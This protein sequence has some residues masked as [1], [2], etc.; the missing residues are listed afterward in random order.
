M[1][2]YTGITLALATFFVWGP[3]WGQVS[4]TSGEVNLVAAENGGRIV[5][6]SSEA[7]DRNG[8]VIPQWAAKNL[9][10]GK[11]V[12]GNFTPP[13]SYGW[14]SDRAPSPDH[15]EWIVFAFKNDETR[16]INRIVI[17]PTTDDPPYIGRWVRDVELQVSTT[18]PNGP[19]KSVGRFVVVNKAIK[20]TFEFPPVEARYVRLLIYSNHG[21]DKCV[22]MGEVEVYEAIVT[23]EALDELIVRLE[24]LLRDLKRYRD[25][26]LHQQ[27][28]ETVERITSKQAPP[29]GAGGASQQGT[30]AAPSQPPQQPGATEQSQPQAK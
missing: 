25:G 17:D 20:Q 10:D 22:E 8:Q 27:V 19:Y 4:F 30:P 24:N 9:I 28:R 29:E 11:Y 18:T 16:L 26:V 13:D 15:P 6:I 7:R 1:V 14:S 21:S 2:K 5:A 12:V 3:S 23:G